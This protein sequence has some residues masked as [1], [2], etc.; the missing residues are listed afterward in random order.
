MPG[1]AAA[2]HLADGGVVAAVA[3]WQR[4]R[5]VMLNE[6]QDLP[7]IRPGGGWCLLVD[8]KKLGLDSQAAAQL[9]LARGKT[10]ATPMTHWGSIR[11][12]DYLRFVYANEP[13]D[14]LRGL[15]DRVCQAWSL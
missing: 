14:R 13:V 9:L 8:T 7:A 10:A 2:L 15:R 5:D 11:A 6:L 1:A 4:R 3:E 12:S